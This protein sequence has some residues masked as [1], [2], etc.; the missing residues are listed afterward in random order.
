M[1][2][3]ESLVED[4]IR[5]ISKSKN[6]NLNKRL[7][8]WNL[9]NNVQDNFDCSFTNFRVMPILLKN[10]YTY[11]INIEE[12]PDYKLYKTYF[13]GLKN[14]DFEFINK[15]PTEEWNR[16]TNPS[17]CYYGENKIF[18]DYGSFLWKKN[19][20]KEELEPKNLD[21]F[22]IALT[23]VKEAEKQKDIDLIYQWYGFVINFYDWFSENRDFKVLKEMYFIEMKQIFLS[24]Y[25]SKNIPEH[26]KNLHI[27][28]QDELKKIS[29]YFKEKLLE[30]M[31]W[32][33]K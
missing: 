3:I 11:V 19:I 18:F 21:V 20:K 16:E 29:Y 27:H 8:I 28:N 24:N 1:Y 12:H 25:D 5:T 31:K 13:E 32:F 30:I 17:T 9:Y 14:V 33:I 15:N 23:L 2:E 4:S 26:H 7:I 6:S 10:A 22:E